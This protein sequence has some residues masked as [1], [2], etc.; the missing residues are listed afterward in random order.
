MVVKQP[1]RKSNQSARHHVNGNIMKRIIGLVTIGLCLCV[2]SCSKENSKRW[3]IA[4][5]H[6]ED[7]VTGLPVESEITLVYSF[8]SSA[9]GATDY[10]IELGDTDSQG[11]IEIQQKITRK[12]TNIH[13]EIRSKTGFYNYPWQI[14]E[15]TEEQP[16]NV[17]GKN[18]LNIKLKPLYPYT[19]NFENVSCT[20]PTDTLW[21]T[22]NVQP[23]MFT[24]CADTSVL[25]AYG[26]T[27]VLNSPILNLDLTSKKA[28]VITSWNESITLTHGALT[29]IQIDY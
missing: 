14:G 4:E 29:E 27:W 21:C 13:L 8:S 23:Q 7:E 2:I 9:L 5:I 15:A 19:L 1:T 22:S 16:L 3:L 11:R 28:G 20:G 12:A 17:K 26:M 18:I 24:G 6:V 10:E 25:S